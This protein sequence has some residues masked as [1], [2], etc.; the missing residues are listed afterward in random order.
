MRFISVL[1]AVISFQANIMEYIIWLIE[2]RNRISCYWLYDW[3]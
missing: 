3:I 2:P 1:N